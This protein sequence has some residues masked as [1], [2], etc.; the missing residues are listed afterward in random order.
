MLMEGRFH[1]WMGDVLVSMPIKDA[2]E[3][4]TTS[5]FLGRYGIHMAIPWWELRLR[6]FFE[7]ETM[8]RFRCR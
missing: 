1:I 5:C 3:A 8:E 4:F 2:V 7:D 6:W